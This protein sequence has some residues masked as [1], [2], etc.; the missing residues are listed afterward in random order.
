MSI[1]KV[2]CGR[3]SGLPLGQIRTLLHSFVA[4]SRLFQTETI[5]SPLEALLESLSSIQDPSAIEATLSFL[6]ESIGRCIRGTFKYID[7]YTELALEVSKTKGLT[8]GFPAVS[9]F[10]VTVVEQWKFFMQS[11]ST[12]STKHAASIWLARF[13]ESSAILG[14][15]KY[16]LAAL[17]E[18]LAASCDESGHRAGKAVFKVLKH[19]LEGEKQLELGNGD[20]DAIVSGF[21]TTEAD[22]SSS[23]VKWPRALFNGIGHLDIDSI[24]MV[25]KSTKERRIEVS[26]FDIAVAQNATLGVLQSRRISCGDSGPALSKLMDL[27]EAILLRLKEEGNLETWGKAKKMLVNHSEWVKSLLGL[28]WEAVEFPRYVYFSK[29]K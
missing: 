24:E 20:A 27:L 22:S 16:V 4:P 10:T 12:S 23:H 21:E 25:T 26:L 1:L 9:P 28:A 11:K 18:R 15:N 13:M 5:A 8:R 17:C 19:Q 3:G 6:D 7:D 14:E 29:S 2:Y